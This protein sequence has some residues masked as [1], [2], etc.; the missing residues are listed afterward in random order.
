MKTLKRSGVVLSFVAPALLL[1]CVFMIYP[2]IEAIRLSLFDWDGSSPDMNF[3]GLE[4]Y[5]ETF[6]D[7]IFGLALKHNLLWVVLDLIIIVIPVLILAVL[8]GKVNKGKLFFRAG[9]YL[10]AVL[11]LPVVGVLWAKIYDPNIGPINIFLKAIGLESISQIWLGNPW[12]VLPAII[13]AGAWSGYG[14]YF[15][16]FMAG[17]QSIDYSLYEAADIDGAGPVRKFWSITIPSLKNT[18]NIVISM[19]IIWGLKS[20]ALIWTLTQ[21]GPFYKSEV[22]ATYV[23][24]SAFAMYDV[25]YGAAGSVILA[26]IVIVLTVLFNSLRE[27]RD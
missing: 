14:L 16:L 4:N 27:G 8:V 6:Q 13:I 12:T 24:K 3:I 23:Y 25:S 18:M 7:K 5:I 1:Y 2:M 19:V 22:V 17:L 15:I 26:I 10:P 11:S 20:F 9:Y 21:G